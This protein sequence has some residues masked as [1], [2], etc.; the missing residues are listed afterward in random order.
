MTELAQSELVFV[1]IL[2]KE[3]GRMPHAMHVALTLTIFWSL[4]VRN[5]VKSF[6]LCET[7]IVG[8]QRKE[9]VLLEIISPC[10]KIREM[11]DGAA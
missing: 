3:E 7:W 2:A 10:R 9:M 6:L 8:R 11:E 1:L 4:I 5:V